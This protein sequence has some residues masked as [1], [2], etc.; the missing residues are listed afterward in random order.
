MKNCKGVCNLPNIT[1]FVCGRAEIP[2]LGSS[3]SGVVSKPLN[4]YA[5]FPI[6][7]HGIKIYAS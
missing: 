5:A 4:Y 6:S 1:Q 3:T 7:I 2:I